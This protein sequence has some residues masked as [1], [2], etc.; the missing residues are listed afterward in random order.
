M[1]ILY[2]GTYGTDDP[3]RA[4][5]PFVYSRGAIEA[6]HEP[7]LFLAGE[8][9][10]LMRPGIAEAVQGFGIASLKELL[11]SVREHSVPVYV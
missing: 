1:K 2:H 9:T 4:S 3:T 7:T 6:G 11:Q 8:A 5:F 10:Y